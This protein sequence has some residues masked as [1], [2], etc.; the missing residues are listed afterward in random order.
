MMSPSWSAEHDGTVI[1][2]TSVNGMPLG[3]D[4]QLKLVDTG[5]KK[6]QRRVRNLASITVKGAE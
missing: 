5:D 3:E 1:V 2:A 6:P 4:G